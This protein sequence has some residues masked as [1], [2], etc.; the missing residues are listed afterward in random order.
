MPGGGWTRAYPVLQNSTM[1]R[2]IPITFL[3]TANPLALV[4]WG[5][6][7]PIQKTEP[8]AQHAEFPL[9][10]AGRQTFEGLASVITWGSTLISAQAA[11]VPCNTCCVCTAPWRGPSHVS[12]LTKHSGVSASPSSREA[13]TLSASALYLPYSCTTLCCFCRGMLLSYCKGQCAVITFWFIT[14]QSCKAL[15]FD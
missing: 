15:T 7:F 14:T 5:F 10:M 11:I 12:A 3:F 6:S 1:P 9:T 13:Q 8:L 2:H 4:W